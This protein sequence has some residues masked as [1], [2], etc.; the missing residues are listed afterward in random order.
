M[1]R[2]V[3]ILIGSAFLGGAAFCAFCAY[4]WW[5]AA[6]G[7][8]TPS[9]YREIYDARGNA[10]IASAILLAVFGILSLWKWRRR[11]DRPSEPAS[12]S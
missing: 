8:P 7:P 5:W 11:P 6:G 10:F 9:P 1:R 12:R 3:P 2:V 4:V